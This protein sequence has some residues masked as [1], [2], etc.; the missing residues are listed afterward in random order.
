[1]EYDYCDSRKL[2]SDMPSATQSSR[3]GIA[4]EQRLKFP[5]S[6]QKF[7]RTLWGALSEMGIGE[8]SQVSHKP[9][10]H[11]ERNMQETTMRP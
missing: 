5:C 9:A 10:T 7:K 3:G 8:V 4:Q 1:M 6:N 2:P 11:Q